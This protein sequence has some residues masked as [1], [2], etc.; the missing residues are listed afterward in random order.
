MRMETETTTIIVNERPEGSDMLESLIAACDDAACVLAAAS[1]HAGGRLVSE[2]LGSLSEARSELS[3]ELIELGM[4]LHPERAR[5]RRRLEQA[6]ERTRVSLDQIAD[7]HGDDLMIL[8]TCM[9]AEDEAKERYEA[10]ALEE[11]LPADLRELVARHLPELERG[12]GLLSAARQGRSPQADMFLLHADAHTVRTLREVV[13]T[14][15]RASAQLREAA[16]RISS[17][18]ARSIFEAYAQKRAYTVG[19]LASLLMLYGATPGA[20]PHPTAIP[21]RAVATDAIL[22]DDCRK[23]EVVTLRFLQRVCEQELPP[24]VASAIKIARDEIEQVHA[25]I[26][27]MC[28]IRVLDA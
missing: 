21:R 15:E 19:K 10:A 2:L 11:D 27:R 28:A 3:L 26:S 6:F 17:L 8:Y 1:R 5:T 23:S 4:S 24:N 22:L 20:G 16:D 18:Q 7:N 25:A 9:L 12:S 14:C 13:A